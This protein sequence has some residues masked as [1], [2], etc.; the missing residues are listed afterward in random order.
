MQGNMLGL[1][2]VVLPLFSW[3][4]GGVREVRVACV[5]RVCS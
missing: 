4:V 3:G 5:M 1:S 2:G